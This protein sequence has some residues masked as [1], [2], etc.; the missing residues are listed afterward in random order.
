M[1]KKNYRLPQEFDKPR[2]RKCGFWYAVEIYG[3]PKKGRG[4]LK[5]VESAFLDNIVADFLKKGKKA[6]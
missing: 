3:K 1:G 4:N 2:L 5:S 6:K